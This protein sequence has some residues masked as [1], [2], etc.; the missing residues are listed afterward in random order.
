MHS[1]F[2][3]L[4]VFGPQIETIEL[5][6]FQLEFLILLW[7]LECSCKSC[8]SLTATTNNPKCQWLNPVEV[9][10]LL[11]SIL[12]QQGWGGD[13]APSTGLGPRFHSWCGSLFHPECL[14]TMSDALIIICECLYFCITK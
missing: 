9:Y 5:I 2:F 8:K 13:S 11:M 10:I 7:S 6:I 4:F 1:H 12:V 14:Q 3:F